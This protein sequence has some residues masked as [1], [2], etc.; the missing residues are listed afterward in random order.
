MAAK[1]RVVC[2]IFFI[3]VY[4][5]HNEQSGSPKTINRLQNHI[6]KKLLNVST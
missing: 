2:L 5:P 6:N 3:F 4:I 1:S